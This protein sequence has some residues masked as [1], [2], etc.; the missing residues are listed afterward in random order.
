[1]DLRGFIKW[2]IDN[3]F[4]NATALYNRVST[5]CIAP[6]QPIGQKRTD[7]DKAMYRFAPT[8]LGDRWRR[9]AVARFLGCERISKQVYVLFILFH[10]AFVN[11]STM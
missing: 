3:G 4:I 6:L 5:C 10:K 9:P 11:P 1:M 8:K 7:I 2:G